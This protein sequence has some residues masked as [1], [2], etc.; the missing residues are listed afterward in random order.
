MNN[1]NYVLGI[2][3]CL[4]CNIAYADGKSA[5]AKLFDKSGH[6]IGKVSFSQGKDGVTV[7]VQ[8]K[9]L[10]AGFHGFHIHAVGECIPPFTTAGPHFEQRIDTNHR[11]H[12]GDMPVLL[13]NNNGKAKAM[14]KTDRFT[15]AE[16]FDSERGGLGRAV[17]IHA[18]P[19]NYANIPTDR[20]TPAPDAT[21]LT[22]GDAGARVVCGV[23][24]KGS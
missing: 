16:L 10:S 24:K 20:Y 18:N 12:N 17:I 1:K 3:I 22:T 6:S 7:M 19:D 5:K 11:D 23:I 2:V 9:G 15:V 8:A 4:L 13:A 14:F 21:T